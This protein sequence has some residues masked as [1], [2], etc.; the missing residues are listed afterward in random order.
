MMIALWFD[1]DMMASSPNQWKSKEIDG[2]RWKLMEINGILKT[3]SQKLIVLLLFIQNFQ[4]NMKLFFQLRAD[5][6]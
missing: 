4:P 3:A 2:N 6:F 5:I 1:D